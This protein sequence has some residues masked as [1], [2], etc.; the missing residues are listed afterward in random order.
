MVSLGHEVMLAC[1]VCQVSK[2]IEDL[3]VQQVVV[4]QLDSRLFSHSDHYVMMMMMMIM[5]NI[6]ASGAVTTLS[7]S[8]FHA[9]DTGE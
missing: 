4:E 8:V 3:L 1:K 2:V 5:N 7:V 9:V 6:D